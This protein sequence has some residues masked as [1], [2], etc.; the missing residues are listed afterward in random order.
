MDVKIFLKKYP[1]WVL[2]YAVLLLIS[3]IALISFSKTDIHLVINRLNTPFLDVFFKYMTEFGSALL[4]VP[5]ILVLAFINYRFSLMAIASSLMGTLGTQLLKRLVYYDSPRPKVVFQDIC[6]LHFVQDVHLHS[7]HSFPSGHTTGAFALFVVLALITKK[8][9]YQFL[10]LLMAVLVGYS[11]MYLS[12]HFLSDVVVG[13]IVGTASALVCYFWL[14]NASYSAK[15]G[16]DGSILKL[17]KP[18][19]H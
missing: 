17:L 16:L 14:N 15:K 4:I 8:P 3:L 12:Q 13:S 19:K 6:Q 18:L 10:F 7:S 2:P 11:R 1:A 5:I 9:L